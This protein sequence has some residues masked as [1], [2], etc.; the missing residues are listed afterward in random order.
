MGAC[1]HGA[2]VVRDRRGQRHARRAV[3]R[4]VE[5]EDAVARVREHEEE[6]GDVW[7]LKHTV[8]RGAEEAARA[9]V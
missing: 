2:A 7:H 1:K 3:R 6:L 4:R 9:V 5:L 8:P